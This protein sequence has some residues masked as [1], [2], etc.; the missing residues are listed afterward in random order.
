MHVRSRLALGALIFC[1]VPLADGVVHAQDFDPR[2]RHKPPPGGRPATP[3]GGRPATPPG[4]RPGPRPGTT[5]APIPGTT[6]TPGNPDAGASQ[7]V[8]I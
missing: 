3:P 8:L 5:P 1:L 4:G 6:P 2:G 7:T